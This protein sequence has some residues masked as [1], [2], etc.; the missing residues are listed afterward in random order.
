MGAGSC[1]PLAKRKGVVREGESE[2]SVMSKIPT[3][4]TRII[5]GMKCGAWLLDKLKPNKLHGHINVNMAGTRKASYA[6]YHG[7]THG[8]SQGNITF[9]VTVEIRFVMSSQPRS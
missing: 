8:R 1:Q 5:S 6:S 9:A 4:G 3:R 7:R 2:G